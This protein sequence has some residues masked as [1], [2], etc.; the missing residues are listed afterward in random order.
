[1]TYTST[2]TLDDGTAAGIDFGVAFIVE[3]AQQ[4]SPLAKIMVFVIILGALLT[5]VKKGI[6][7]TKIARG[8]AK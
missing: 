7:F 3:L 8:I 2:Y 1:M 5:I 4:A 6:G